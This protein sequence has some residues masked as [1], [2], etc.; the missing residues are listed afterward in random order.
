M[1]VFPVRPIIPMRIDCITL[2]HRSP[3]T[4]KVL[5]VI[6]NIY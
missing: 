6:V 3:G 2:T 4:G 5:R 1:P